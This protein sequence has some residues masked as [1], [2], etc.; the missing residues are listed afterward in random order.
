MRSVA[1]AM[2]RMILSGYHYSYQGG[3]PDSPLAVDPVAMSATPETP[4]TTTDQ[5]ASWCT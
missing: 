4:A 2:V 3:K 1:D 5:S